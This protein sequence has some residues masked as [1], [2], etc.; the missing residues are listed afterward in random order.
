MKPRILI[1]ALTIAALAAAT[2]APR[3]EADPLTVMAVV[4]LASV[5]AVSSI[6]IIAGGDEDGKE[7]RAQREESEKLVARAEPGAEASEA[8]AVKAD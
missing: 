2:P 8:V 3:A 5:F 7:Q 4:G 6:D 1:I